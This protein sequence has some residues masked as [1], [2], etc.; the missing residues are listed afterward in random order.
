[1]ILHVDKPTFPLYL[2][3][4]LIGRLDLKLLAGLDKLLLALDSWWTSDPVVW[5]FSN[6]SGG[7]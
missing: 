1:M 5:L 4:W 2:D 7:F 6:E 3:N